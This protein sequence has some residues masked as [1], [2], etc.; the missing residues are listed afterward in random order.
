M[1]KSD[2]KIVFLS[3]F[4]NHHQAYISRELY[5]L[6]N[7]NFK[8][9]SKKRPSDRIKKFGYPDLKD[10]FVVVYDKPSEEVQKII[11]TADVVICGSSPEIWIEN[12][13]KQR[14][15]ILRYSERP[16]K[17]GKELWKYPYRF[18]K[19][20]IQT[21]ICSPIYMLCASAYTASDYLKFGLYKGKTFK[22]GYFPECKRYES[23]EALMAQKTKNEILWCGRFLDWKHP[24][25]VLEIAK[26]L[27]DNGKVF[28]INFIGSGEMQHELEALCDR[29]QLFD[30]VTFVGSVSTD[31]VRAY[32]ENASIYLF[33]SDRQEGWGAVLNEAMNSAC[34]VVA[35]DEAGSTPYLI[36][37]G[38]NGLVYHSGDLNCLYQT[39]EKLLEKTEMQYKLGLKAYET[40][41]NEWNAE[42]AAKRL[43][44]LCENILAG[45]DAQKIYSNGPCSKA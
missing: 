15:L 35:S 7:G 20:H 29:Y 30:Y 37:D 6:T 45:E 42:I 43:H 36:Q 16:L 5:K 22:W 39:L 27:K 32:M 44:T 34:A 24:D 14:K 3:N 26:R 11:D 18:L 40:I 1:R 33:T 9:I 25:D 28:H 8:F 17:K 41:I 31:R 13:K 23:I 19:W 2:M 12:R 10:E 4:Y 38:V 21:P